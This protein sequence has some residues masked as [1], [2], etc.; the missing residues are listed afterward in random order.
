MRMH[1]F[2]T[3]YFYRYSI[4]LPLQQFIKG[5]V[6]TISLLKWVAALL[7]LSAFPGQRDKKKKKKKK[8]KIYI[9]IYIYMII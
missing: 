1:C 3:P 2:G 5:Y 9:Y 8:K 6:F 7:L 4:R